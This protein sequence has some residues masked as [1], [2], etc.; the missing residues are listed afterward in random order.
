MPPTLTQKNSNFTWRPIILVAL[1][2]SFLLLSMPPLLEQ[3]SINH[4]S[5]DFVAH[6]QGS[7]R[8]EEAFPHPPDDLPHSYVWQAVRAMNSEEYDQVLAIM[9]PY[10]AAGNRYAL[11]F[12]G[13]AR[14]E[15]GDYPGAVQIWKQLEDAEGLLGL[16]EAAE[17]AGQ[18][19]VAHSA[20]TAAWQIDPQTT[21]GTFADFLE[22]NGDLAGAEEV[23]RQGIQ[24]HSLSSRV[25]PYLYQRLAELMMK[26]ERWN[27]AVQAWQGTIEYADFFYHP[28]SKMDRVYYQLSWAY[29]MDGQN[30]K[31]IDAIEKALA[32]NPN[33]KFYLRAGQIYTA[34][35]DTQSALNAYQQALAIEPNNETALEAIKHINDQ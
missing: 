21:T 4:Q 23:L 30:A 28:E 7:H 17:Q 15:L 34:A 5:L 27:E 1:G 13:L 16:A 20:Y 33:L 9:E 26:Q 2:L 3:W 14:E 24:K 29:H 18:T 25:R 35:G 10:A 32:L 11:E 8:R 19:Q 31:A 22:R 12:V 6:V